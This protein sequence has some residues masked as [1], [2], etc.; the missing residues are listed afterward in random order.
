MFPGEKRVRERHEKMVKLGT[1]V[2]Y[3]TIWISCLI[4]SLLLLNGR[5]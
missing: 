2:T 5:I 3:G 4:I 1:V